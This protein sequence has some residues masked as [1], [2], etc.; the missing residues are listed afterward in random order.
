MLKDERLSYLGYVCKSLKDY[1]PEEVKD[2]N[3]F[4][5]RIQ[6]RIR[7]QGRKKKRDEAGVDKGSQ[8]N[9]DDDDENIFFSEEEEDDDVD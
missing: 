8:N 9:E 5:Q 6:E 7:R 1:L 2:E 4:R 3:A